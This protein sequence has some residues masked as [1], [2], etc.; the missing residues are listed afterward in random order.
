[1]IDKIAQGLRDIG[2]EV[3]MR[4]RNDQYDIK[5]V[6]GVDLWVAYLAGKRK[7]FFLRTVY[8]SNGQTRRIKTGC[9]WHPEVDKAVKA[10]SAYVKKR[11]RQIDAREQQ[12]L[13]QQERLRVRGKFQD[14]QSLE[15]KAMITQMREEELRAVLGNILQ[16]ALHRGSGDITATTVLKGIRTQFQLGRQ[17]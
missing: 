9:F 3:K 17:S 15:Y 13:K 8:T 1:M 12:D 6:G 10:I 14:Q 2:H 16:V 5:V 11:Q 7:A 4:T